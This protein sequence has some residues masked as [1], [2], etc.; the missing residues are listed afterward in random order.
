MLKMKVLDPEIRINPEVSHPC[1][2]LYHIYCK[3]SEKI[4]LVNSVAA[5]V[6]PDQGL[7]FLQL[8]Q[9]NQVYLF[10]NFG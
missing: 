4:G 7:H 8:I 5:A 10:K 9:Q 3:Y 1:I 6:A 2:L